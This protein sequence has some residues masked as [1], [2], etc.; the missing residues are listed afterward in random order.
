MQMTSS[1]DYARMNSRAGEPISS[2]TSITN[3]PNDGNHLLKYK[4]EEDE[5][6]RT[7][8][9]WYKNGYNNMQVMMAT[10]PWE[11]WGRYGAW[12]QAKSFIDTA[13]VPL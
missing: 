11:Y 7:T 3:E 9:V 1:N 4:I 2:P 10:Y 6:L 8:R 13:V 12:A 5:S